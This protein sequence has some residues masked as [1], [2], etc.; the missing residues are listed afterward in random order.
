MT[1]HFWRNL[2]DMEYAQFVWIELAQKYYIFKTDAK[3]I[4]Y[5]G[6]EYVS[7]NINLLIKLL[8]QGII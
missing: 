6:S 3:I 1:L 8:V 5:T 4:L 2:L 7:P